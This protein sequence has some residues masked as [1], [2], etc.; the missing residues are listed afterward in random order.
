MNRHDTT[1]D[2]RR[3]TKKR[4]KKKT[5]KRRT[6]KLVVLFVFVFVFAMPPP[7]KRTP[8]MQNFLRKYDKFTAVMVVVAAGMYGAEYYVSNV[9]GKKMEENKQKN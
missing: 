5:P 4:E 6:R 8:E 3:R 9:R 7:T 1:I 2:E